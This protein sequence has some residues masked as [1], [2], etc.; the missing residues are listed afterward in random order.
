LG[1][2]DPVEKADDVGAEE[3]GDRASTEDRIDQSGEVGAAPSASAEASGFSRQ[4]FLTDALHC[5]RFG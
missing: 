4:V 3:I 2:F 1:I 5:L